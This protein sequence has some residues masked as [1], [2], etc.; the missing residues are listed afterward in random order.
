MHLLSQL[1]GEQDEYP[2]VGSSMGGYVSLMAS[3][4]YKPTGPFLMATALY[5]PD[6][7]HRTY[8]TTHQNIEIVHGWYDDI[9]LP[10][11]SIRFAKEADCTLHL[12]S[13]NHRLNDSIENVVNLFRQFLMAAVHN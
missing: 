4:K 11:Q 10:E 8:P 6:Y 9:V 3:A 13:G 5:M 1:Q 2:L 7:E 12:I